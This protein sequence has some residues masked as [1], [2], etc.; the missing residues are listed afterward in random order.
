MKRIIKFAIAINGIPYYKEQ[1]EESKSLSGLSYELRKKHIEFFEGNMKHQKAIMH[2]ED[3]VTSL[4]KLKWEDILVTQAHFAM[5]YENYWEA[6][7][8]TSRGSGLK[9]SCRN[10][11]YPIMIAPTLDGILIG[12]FIDV[13]N[14]LKDLK[15]FML[16]TRKGYFLGYQ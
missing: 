5:V 6:F 12:N 13:E 7:G 3:L 15:N 14:D 9:I 2:R 10:E 16:K 8:L 4:S 1:L 11:N